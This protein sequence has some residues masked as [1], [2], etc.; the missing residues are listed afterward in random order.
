MQD[1]PV[2]VEN[3]LDEA[4]A[5]VDATAGTVGRI[6]EW[7]AANG[8]QWAIA[9]GVIVGVYLLLALLRTT[10]TKI[11]GH[12]DKPDWSVRNV[13][14]GLVKATNSLFLIVLSVVIVVPFFVVLREWQVEALQTAFMIVGT[15]Q[16][17]FWARVVVKALLARVSDKQ[18]ADESTLANAMSLIIVFVNVIVF[19]V[20]I[21]VILSNLGMDVT[22]LVAGLGVG[23]IA[24]GLA[25]QSLFEDLFAGLSIILDKPFVRGDFIIFGDKMGSVERVGLKSTRIRTLSGQ[26]LT[27][28][29][30]NLLGNEI[31]NYRRMAERRIVSSVGVTYS[32]PHEK[33]ERLAAQI[34]E[35]VEATPDVR[36][37]R[38]H[39]AAF[40]DFS[41]NFEF[42]YYV[43]SKEYGVYMDAQQK[44]FL[45]I[46]A[47]FERE[48]IE[49]AFPTQTLHIDSV[50]RTIEQGFAK[51]AAE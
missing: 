31:N 18:S 41:I 50:P 39:L 23:G 19:A 15:L 32:T 38:S 44:I 16:V 20:A 46:H 6:T 7:I 22:G 21:V 35:I 9:I 12:S 13:I 30:S 27:V 2:Q 51:A 24:I 3:V 17:A 45:A 25:A 34:R 1:E 36:F 10:L 26:Q 48:G 49:F 11:V 29:N 43:L 4:S 14:A 33:L 40:A 8:V 37:D 5:A 42:V 47:L 28:N